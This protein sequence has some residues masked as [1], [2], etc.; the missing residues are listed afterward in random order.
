MVVGHGIGD[1][2]PLAPGGPVLRS[3]LTERLTGIPITFSGGVYVAEGMLDVVAPALLIPYLLLV[4]SLPTWTHWVLLGIL[5]QAA[6]L[7]AMLIVLAMRSRIRP[8]RWLL[9]LSA[10][11]LMHLARQVI[12][13]LRAVTA[14]GPKKCLLVVGLSWLVIALMAGQVSLFLRAF[15]LRGSANGLFLILVVMLSAGSV[16][17]KIPA[18]GTVTAAAVLPVAGIRG[19]EVGGYLLLSQFLLSSETVALAALVLGWWFLRR[20]PPFR[21][22]NIWVREPDTIAGERPVIALTLSAHAVPPHFASGALAPCPQSLEYQSGIIC[23]RSS[24]PPFCNEK[25]CPAGP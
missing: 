14:G 6:L 18:F 11:R 17:I 10:P 21:A 16:P 25:P 20:D 3:V 12:E 7:L 1:L 8:G 13:G 23:S 19:P 4:L 15:G 2:F 24:E 9:H 22:M 5:T